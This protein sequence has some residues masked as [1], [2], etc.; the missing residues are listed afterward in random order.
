MDSAVWFGNLHDERSNRPKKKIWIKVLQH[1]FMCAF[2]SVVQNK[3]KHEARSKNVFCKNRPNLWQNRIHYITTSTSSLYLV[4]QK[5]LRLH[6]FMTDFLKHSKNPT[7]AIECN[8]ITLNFC[9]FWWCGY[10][11]MWINSKITQASR[12]VS[13]WSTTHHLIQRTKHQKLSF[14]VFLQSA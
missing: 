9:L 2:L 12:L 10:Y 8:Q 13:I 7:V 5:S 14:F 3:F 4:I 6:Y 11:K 1:S